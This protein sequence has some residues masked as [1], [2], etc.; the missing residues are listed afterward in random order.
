MKFP[1]LINSILHKINFYPGSC[2]ITHA[3]AGST[4]IDGILRSLYW[5]RVA[6]RSPTLIN[7]KYQPGRIYS[8]LFITREE[9]ARA[10]QLEALDRFVVIRDLRDTLCSFYF[11]IRNT[12]MTGNR[13][14]YL[15]KEREY[16]RRF[17][18]LDGLARVLKFL[19]GTYDIQL[20]WLQ[21]GEPVYK[22][23]KLISDPQLYLK[24][25]IMHAFHPARPNWLIN[26]AFRI[27]SFTVKYGRQL[28]EVDCASHGRVGLP[29]DWRNYFTKS[30]GEQ[31]LDHFGDILVLVA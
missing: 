11:S 9:L 15:E 5:N 3:K 24:P 7:V 27:N 1:P 21:T 19:K 8:A 30:L 18:T 31:F 22:Y 14:E 23:E 6:S 26:R 20:S 17:S 13:F 25:I 28:G 16:L 4:W 10:P 12:H 2:F 29:G